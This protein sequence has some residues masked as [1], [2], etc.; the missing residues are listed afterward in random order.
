[1]KYS[2]TVIEP[3][4]D[5]GSTPSDSANSSI[6]GTT[7]A[8]RLSIEKLRLEVEILRRPWWRTASNLGPIATIAAAVLGLVWAV[9][10]GFFDVSRRELDL[11]KRELASEMRDLQERRDAQAR[12]FQ[13][14]TSAQKKV[15][16]AMREEAETLRKRL[17]DLDK[18]IL[19]GASVR[20][21]SFMGMKEDQLVY[22]Y[23][24]GDNFGENSG[25]VLDGRVSGFCEGRGGAVSGLSLGSDHRIPVTVTRWSPTEV[26][27]TLKQHDV[28]IAW[29]DA[30]RETLAPELITEGVCKASV[31]VSLERA[32]KRQ[33]TSARIE[34]PAYWLD[35]ARAKKLLRGK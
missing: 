4:Q 10:S 28:H 3:A 27:I 13:Q 11:R 16:L 25:R 8:E 14:E 23:L 31:A 19:N 35:I 17:V 22:A 5:E 18:P 6:V 30:T 29:E 21:D 12:K 26:S 9:A 32:D 7:E 2:V 15:I 33:S 20:L 24:H 1:L 34:I